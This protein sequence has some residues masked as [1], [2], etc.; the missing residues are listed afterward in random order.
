MNQ[1]AVAALASARVEQQQ[2]TRR[3]A[4]RKE[5]SMAAFALASCVGSRPDGKSMA[6][7]LVRLERTAWRAVGGKSRWASWRAR[8][9]ANELTIKIPKT[10]MASRPATRATA[11]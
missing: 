1:V 9:V 3:K 6:A 10:A 2:A 8:R 11:L 7:S 5:S 4:K